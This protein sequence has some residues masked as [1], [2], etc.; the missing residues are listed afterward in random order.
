MTESHGPQVIKLLDDVG[1]IAHAR[2]GDAQRDAFE[3]FASQYFRTVADECRN[4]KGLCG[5]LGRNSVIYDELV[6]GIPT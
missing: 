1:E 3:E 6:R 4:L 5:Q 2:L